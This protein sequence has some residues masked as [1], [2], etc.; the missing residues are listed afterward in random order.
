[1]MKRL[2]FALFAAG[3][4]LSLVR[5]WKAPVGCARRLLEPQSRLSA[6]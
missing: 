2:M 4:L 1:M 3:I 6:R 5:E